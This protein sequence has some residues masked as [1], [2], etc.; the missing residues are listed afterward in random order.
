ME[1]FPSEASVF[2]LVE[3]LTSKCV[4][5]VRLT[6]SSFIFSDAFVWSSFHRKVDFWFKR[7]LKGLPRDVYF[8][9]NLMYWLVDPKNDPNSFK[10][11]DIFDRFIFV[12]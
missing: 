4:F 6:I 5:S 1:L 2:T 7:G 9:T 8:G 3:R 12:N 11:W 10:F